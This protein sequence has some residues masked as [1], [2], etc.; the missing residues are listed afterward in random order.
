MTPPTRAGSRSAFGSP[1]WIVLAIAGVVIW[2]AVLQLRAFNPDGISYIEI[3]KLFSAG[4]VSAV[5]NG[6]WSPL[7]PIVVAIALRIGD[8][9]PGASPSELSVVLATNL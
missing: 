7:Y 1:T 6:Y 8:L 4:D 5:S 2:L 3:A 9:W